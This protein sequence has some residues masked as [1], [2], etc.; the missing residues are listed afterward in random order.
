[1]V[2]VNNLQLDPAKKAA[3][4]NGLKVKDIPLASMKIFVGFQEENCTMSDD[5]YEPVLFH[6]IFL[7]ETPA[8]LVNSVIN[9]FETF[10]KEY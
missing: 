3:M 1:V 2:I 8:S 10:I 4:I 6:G 7:P 5:D 9:D